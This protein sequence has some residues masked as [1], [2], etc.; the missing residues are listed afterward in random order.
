MEV[1]RQCDQSEEMTMRMSLALDGQLGADGRRA[2]DVHLATCGTCRAEWE[3]MQAIST[4]LTESAMIGPPLGFAIRVERRLGER[5]KK[6]R[7][8]F[9]SVAVL[10]SSLSLASLTVVAL[11]IVLGAILVWQWVAPLPSVQQGT[12]VASKLASGAGLLGKGATLFLGDLLLQYGP[13]L[14]AAVALGL[15]LLA[16]LWVWLVVRRPGGS[17]NRNGY[18]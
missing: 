7:R 14:A 18:A 6:R 4:M 17:H 1:K 13:P 5:A 11:V 16:G 15:V 10:T 12:E 9:G 8:V 2:L 3:A